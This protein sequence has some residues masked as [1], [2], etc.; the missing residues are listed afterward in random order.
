M[1]ER[2]AESYKAFKEDEY[3]LRHAKQE[4]NDKTWFE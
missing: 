3:L 4:Y 2:I 1:S